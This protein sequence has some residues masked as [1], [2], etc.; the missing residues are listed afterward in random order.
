MA[1]ANGGAEVTDQVESVK[2]ELRE[3][4]IARGNKLI[5]KSRCKWAHLG[6]KPSDHFLK[7]L[8]H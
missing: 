6:E 7:P 2:G 8:V 3:V 4:E 5:F 1:C